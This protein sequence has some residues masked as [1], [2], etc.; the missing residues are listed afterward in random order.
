VAS[1]SE[2][3]HGLMR[4][5]LSIRGNPRPPSAAHEPLRHAGASAAELPLS[6][7][8]AAPGGRPLPWPSSGPTRGVRCPV[9]P[10]CT[11]RTRYRLG[12]ERHFARKPNKRPWCV[13]STGFRSPQRSP[14]VVVRLMAKQL[15]RGK[16]R[17]SSRSGAVRGACEQLC[18]SRLLANP[19]SNETHR[20]EGKLERAL[21]LLSARENNAA[22]RKEEQGDAGS[23]E[24]PHPIPDRLAAQRSP[25]AP[26]RR[27][28]PGDSTAAGWARSTPRPTAMQQ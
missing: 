27:H 1:A 25:H 14:R 8:T 13:E 7:G 22:D 23:H 4:F 9:S 16:C 6:T 19:S 28:A 24:I 3:L 15:L 2:R 10:A 20:T 5:L 11:P 17:V 18:S 12:Q 26:S 21:S